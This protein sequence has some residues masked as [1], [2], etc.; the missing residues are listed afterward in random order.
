MLLFQETFLLGLA[1]DDPVSDEVKEPFCRWLKGLEGV[2]KMSVPRSYF[3]VGWYGVADIEIHE[4][5]DTSEFKYGEAVCVR[6]TLKDGSVVT[7]LVMSR[8]RV[9]PLK[10]VS[11]PRLE[12]L[13]ALLAVRL[14]CPQSSETTYADRLAMLDRFR[15]CCVLDP[16]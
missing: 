14:A 5:D 13:G 2:K 12:L 7:P 10:R 15:H 4:F 9:A 6:L 16:K 11:V 8:A 3:V 1:W